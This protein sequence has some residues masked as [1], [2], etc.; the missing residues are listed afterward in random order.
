MNENCIVKI[1]PL[2][3]KMIISNT[4]KRTSSRLKYDAGRQVN[5]HWSEM[6]LLGERQ[7]SGL[8]L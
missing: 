3:F 8:S 4:I 5:Y 6:L 2:I 1:K 7:V